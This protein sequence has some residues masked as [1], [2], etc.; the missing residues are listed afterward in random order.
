MGNPAIQEIDRGV[1]MVVKVVP[2]SS[3]TD[4]CGPFGEMLKIKVSAAPERGKANQ[5]LVRFLAQRLG[6]KKSAIRI[7]AGQTSTVKQ[8]LVSGISA[9]MLLEKLNLSQQSVSE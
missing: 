1:L 2:G 5:C 3:R 4:V 7:I 6:L 8:I 9:E